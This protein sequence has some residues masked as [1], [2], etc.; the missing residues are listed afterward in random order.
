MERLFFVFGMVLI[1][2]GI[3]LLIL[4]GASV[5]DG[6][7][8]EWAELAVFSAMSSTLCGLWFIDK[9]TDYKED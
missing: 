6:M 2:A 3:L 4:G 1:F 5:I 9:S 8:G 7:Q